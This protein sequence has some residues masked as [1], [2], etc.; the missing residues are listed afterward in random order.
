MLDDAA[1]AFEAHAREYDALRRRLVPCLDAFYRVAV[2]ALGLASRR[3]RRIL[4]LGAGTGLLSARLAAAHPD[5]ELV[6]LDASPAMLEQARHAVGPRAVSHVADLRDP[7]PAGLFDG[8]VSALAIHHIDDMAKRDLFARVQA[9][10]IPGGVFVNAEQVA[11]PTTWLD[12]HYRAHHREAS[13]ELGTT[14]E[15][16]QAAE[17]RMA[18]D[19]CATTGA[20]LGWLRE[21][22][23]VDVDCLYKDHRFAVLFARVG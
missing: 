16:W 2:D 11:G 13:A 18:L 17:K 15:E 9:A 10:V 3:P 12:A 21:A 6:L 4:D 1:K 7:L 20:Q 8:V 19:R 14:A 22:G 5:A 23:F